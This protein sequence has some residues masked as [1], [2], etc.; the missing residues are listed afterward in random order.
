MTFSSWSLAEKVAQ[1]FMV[2]YTGETPQ[3]L[4]YRFLERGVGGLIFFRDNFEPLPDARAVEELLIDLRHRVPAHLP[5]P[6]LGI[7]QEGGQVER[8][9]H[10]YFP[11]TLTPH[12]VAHSPQ[13][14]ALARSLYKQMAQHLRALGFTLDFFPTL[15]VN[16]NRHN[17]IIGVRSFGDDP[18]AVWRFSEIALQEFS[19]AGLLTAGKHFPG[20][21]NGTVDSHLDLPTLH[22]TEEE[23][24]PFRQAI[25]S[26][27]PA[28]LVAHGYYPALQT[29]PEERQLP[30]SASPVVIQKLLRQQLGFDGIVITDDMCM[31]AITK[32]RDP[33][34]AALASLQAGVDIL[35]YKQST[36]TEWQV[37]EAV[38]QAFSE[39]RLPMSQLEKSLTRILQWKNWLAAQP[40]SPLTLQDFSP[41]V[42]QRVTEPLAQAG[43]GLVHGSSQAIQVDLDA[44]LLV[45]HPDRRV[46]GNYAFDVD[47]SPDLDILL[48]QAGY[49][50]LQ[51]ITYPPKQPFD[52]EALLTNISDTSQTIVLITFN[53]LLQPEQATLYQSLCQRF[54]TTRLLVASAGMPDLPPASRLPDTHISLCSYR[55]ATLRALAQ[56]LQNGL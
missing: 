7:D 41:E 51:S 29:T 23:L 40:P 26:G 33:V 36:E 20:H 52:A 42:L 48:K 25:Q 27:I 2:G 6:L 32:H 54:P 44:P 50:H 1:L 24:W 35:L 3:S 55:P 43:I 22:F 18:Q 31:G 15:D 38:I 49:T 53:P 47:S 13:P 37:Y 16:L 34:E 14:E 46:M 19:Q 5:T 56:A 8:L 30:S 12:A 28:I 17:P 11:T 9:P 45:I 10:R 4:T 21:G 39:G